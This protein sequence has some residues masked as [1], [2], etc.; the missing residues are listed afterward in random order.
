MNTEPLVCL[1]FLS[2]LT[3]AEMNNHLILSFT[4]L[5]QSPCLLIA[6]FF[7]ASGLLSHKKAVFIQDFLLHHVYLTSATM[8]Q[9]TFI[10]VN[11]VEAF[12]KG[13]AAPLKRDETHLDIAKVTYCCK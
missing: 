2:S 10:G 7:L 1:S 5:R 11:A 12:R 9:K 3:L 8:M 4:V 13:G 6:V